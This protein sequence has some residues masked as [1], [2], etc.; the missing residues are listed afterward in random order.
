MTS[1]NSAE[2]LAIALMLDALLGEPKWLYAR[3]PH[4][5][6]LMGNAVAWADKRF[7]HEQ[8]T[9]QRR[10]LKGLITMAALG[11]SALTIGSLLA[12]LPALVQ[13]VLVATLLAHRSLVDHVCAVGAALRLSTTDAQ[14]AVARIVSRDTASMLPPAIARSAIESGAENF[15]DGVIA[16]AFWFLVAGIPG[17][18]LYKITNTAD[19]MIG[20]RTSRHEDFGRAAALFD[21]LLNLLPARLSAALIA[22]TQGQLS[23]W[24]DIRTDAKLHKSPNAGWPESAMAR[25]LDVALAGPRAYGGTLRDFAWVNGEG[26][27][28]IGADEIEASCRVLWRAWGA[29]LGVIVAAAIASTLLASQL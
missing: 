14:H 6:V 18:L 20:Y 9:P 10:Q 13:A 26:R 21:D 17:L 28:T 12:V 22:S 8:D 27:K 7:N 24:L 15:S 5:A 11:L 16:P 25:A 3:L 29:A 19:S 23:H 4:P 1:M 2:I